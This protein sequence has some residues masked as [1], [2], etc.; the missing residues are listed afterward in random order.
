MICPSC[1]RSNLPGGLRC[2]YC[3][4][5]LAQ[6][7][8]FDLNVSAAPEAPAATVSAPAARGNPAGA[9]RAVGMLGSLGLL[10][11]KAKTFLALLSLGKL[12]TTFG[13]M[14]V[15]IVAEAQLYGWKLAVGFAVSIFVHEMGH[16]VVNWTKG[17]KQSAPVFIPFAGAVIFLKN[18]PDNPTIQSESGAG[19]PIAGGLAAF[20]CL[21]IGAATGEPFWYALAS[22]GFVINLFNLVPFPPLDGSHIT[23]VFSPRLWNLVI[24][25]MLL[26]ALKTLSMVWLWPLIGIGIGM[27]LMRSGETRYLMAPPLVR[28][29]M[30]AIYL[31]LAI[32]LSWGAVSTASYFPMMKFPLA[33]SREKTP[34]AQTAEQAKTERNQAFREIE[35]D[36]VTKRRTANTSSFERRQAALLAILKVIA[37]MLSVIFWCVAVSL[38]RRA[39]G[40]RED[41]KNGWLIAGATALFAPILI[42][43]SWFHDEGPIWAYC[44]AATLTLAYSIYAAVAFGKQRQKPAPTFLRHRALAWAAAG[45]A[46]VAYGMDSGPAAIVLG[47]LILFFYLRRPGA[48]LAVLAQGAEALGDP[49]RTLSLRTKAAEWSREPEESALLWEEVEKICLQLDRGA[50]ALNARARRDTAL[51]QW[52]AKQ[53][54]GAAPLFDPL[55]DGEEQIAALGL[56]TRYADALTGCERLLQTAS[57]NPRTAPLGPFFVHRELARLALFRGWYDE[58]QAQAE[59]CINVLSPDAKPLA[60]PL[61][62]VRA[63]A[64]AGRAAESQGVAR[65]KFLDAARAAAD[66]A[67]ENNREPSLQARVATIRAQLAL[68]TGDSATA[69]TEAKRAASLFPGHLGCRYWRARTVAPT[70]LPA[71]AAAFPEDYWGKKAEESVSR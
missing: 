51:A 28:A 62:A 27:R 61:H 67:L 39:S 2:A 8:D 48:F 3:G 47:V 32:A 42:L 36:E 58:A 33:S 59:W 63:E 14:F 29:R 44:A 46:L 57:A 12:V 49:E 43:S 24:V 20:V 71:L 55:T 15:F 19:G 64:L 6:N 4:T 53:K 1:H 65:E 69:A 45:A 66:R 41:G 34:A 17:L 68:L 30:A 26:L 5:Y 21:G 37:A 11:L 60:A 23:S 52:Q 9:A 16:V 25:A 7:A 13:S 38:L 35:R 40:R 10:L 31:L 22:L 54:A 18:F 70:D 56:A 50:D